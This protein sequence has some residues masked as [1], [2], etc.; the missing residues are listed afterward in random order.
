MTRPGAA[1]SRGPSP[2]AGPFA[3]RPSPRRPAVV[4]CQPVS[5]QILA[6]RSRPQSFAEVV[7]Q[8]AVVRALSNALAEDRIAHAYLFSGIR[9]VGKTSVAR[10]LAKAL[11]CTAAGDVEP[12]NECEN[13]RE[14]TSGSSLNVIEVDAATYSKVD[15]IRE[16][17]DGLQYGPSGGRYKVVI[18]DEIH[19]L[20]KQAFDALLKIVEEPPAHLVF[21]FATTDVDAVPATILS[22]CQEFSFRRVPADLLTAHLERL[23]ESEGLTVESGSLRRIARAAEGS[24]RDAVALLDQLSTLGDGAI[25]DAEVARLLGGLD[26]SALVDL[27]AAVAA[28]ERTAVSEQVAAVRN[29]GRDPRRI[30]NELLGF[31]REALHLA[32]GVPGEAVDLP[33]DER[34]RLAALVDDWGYENVLRLVQHLLES[35]PLLRQVDTPFLALELA[36]L[37]AAELPRLV[38]LEALLSGKLPQSTDGEAG[39]RTPTPG[40]QRPEPRTAAPETEPSGGSGETAERTEQTASE[41]E[42]SVQDESPEPGPPGADSDVEPAGEEAA[43]DEPSADDPPDTEPT[44]RDDGGSAGA[45]FVEA[46]R[47]N[48]PSL[49]AHLSRARIAVEGNRLKVEHAADDRLLVQS[50]NRDSSQAALER[51]AHELLG[52]AAE[53]ELAASDTL[54]LRGANGGG[55]AEAGASE[56]HARAAQDPQVQTVLD[57]F[58]GEVAS[59][60]A[61]DEASSEDQRD[62]R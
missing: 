61:A 38:A 37:R 3:C 40:S 15:Q 33:S 58:N 39:G 49:A 57:I 43:T 41:D 22:R 10:I 17:T 26:L 51:A 62:E 14:I 7:G 2:T 48:K 55:R 32:A 54:E 5:Y 21:I 50:W 53:V 19:R 25:D 30:Y 12:C 56:E 18:I 42:G 24:V 45:L 1:D 8:E 44:A 46:V 11:N 29:A 27:F 20:S 6:R 23:R 31:A 35:E 16:L 60:N 52:E 9:G 13:C 34:E 36:L 47:V 59:V 4:P 28:G